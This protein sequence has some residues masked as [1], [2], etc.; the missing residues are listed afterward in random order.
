MKH[1][2]DTGISNLISMFLSCI[3][4][5]H[6]YFVIGIYF[7]FVLLVTTRVLSYV[8]CFRLVTTRVMSYVPRFGLVTTRVMS[9][10]PRFRLVTNRVMSFVPCFG[11]IIFNLFSDTMGQ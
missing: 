11:L 9:Y 8:P 4:I 6:M 1:I 3:E 2:K 10:V 5:F 7:Y